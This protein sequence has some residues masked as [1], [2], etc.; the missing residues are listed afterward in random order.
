MKNALQ[1]I[2]LADV[3]LAAIEGGLAPVFGAA[4]IVVGLCTAAYSFGDNIGRAA[5]DAVNWYEQNYNAT[6]SDTSLWDSSCN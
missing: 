2:E 3:Q 6:R 5:G 4:A 1:P